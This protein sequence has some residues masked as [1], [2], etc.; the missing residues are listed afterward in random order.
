[1]ESIWIFFAAI[2]ATTVSSMSG[3]GSSVIAV[4][5]FLSM[6]IPLPMAVAMQSIS[7]AFWVKG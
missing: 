7:G 1:M 2:I 3:G 4:P 6:G 5:I